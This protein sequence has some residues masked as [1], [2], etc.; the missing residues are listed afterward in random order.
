MSGQ[1]TLAQRAVGPDGMAKPKELIEIH[2]HHL[3]T[4]QDR[5]LYSTL[6]HLIWDDLGKEQEHVVP[7][8]L[9]RGTS[10][11]S[12]DQIKAAAWR[13]LLTGVVVRIADEAGEEGTLRC[14]LI[15]Q[16]FDLD[17]D[18]TPDGNLRFWIAPRLRKALLNSRQW[19]R[20][21]PRIC[22]AF[23]SKYALT[24]YE[25]L[26]LRINRN[27]TFED[28]SVADFRSLLGVE[29][30]RYL[31]YCDFNK[32]VLKIA[33]D[34]VNGLS[35]INVEITPIRTGGR[36]RG[37]IEGYRMIWQVK[38]AEEWKRASD[39]INRHSAGRHVRL[40]GKDQRETV[41]A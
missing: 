17:E 27:N 36:V 18:N 34:E 12:N 3:L 13:L 28:W 29:P 15:S 9:L 7:M 38:T 8:K 41:A 31:A 4:L 33:A 21:K 16:L 23:S 26:C 22:F 1:L 14:T 40:S 37:K 25:N 30:G 10:H 5:R 24:L 20:I 11:E 35:D 39:E 2:E 6:I 19:G 32:R